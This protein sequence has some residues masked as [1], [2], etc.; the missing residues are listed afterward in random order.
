MYI[1]KW[2]LLCVVIGTSTMPM[3]LYAAE[4]TVDL[5][6][7]VALLKNQLQVLE[8]R[9]AT[10]DQSN[11]DVTNDTGTNN[12][13]NIADQNKVSIK[14]P[15]PIQNKIKKA[16]VTTN[17]K[18][19]AAVSLPSDTLSSTV[20]SQKVNIAS[21]TNLPLSWHGSDISALIVGGATA[22][23]SKSFGG[24]NSFNL[25]DLNPVLLFSYK[26]LILMRSALNFAIND[27]GG[28]DVSLDNVN[29][30]LFINDYMIFGIGKFDSA[31]GSFIQNLS[32]SWVNRLPDSP[33]GFSSDQAAPQSEIGVQ[34]RGGLPLIADINANYILFIANGPQG[35][36]DTTN[37][38]IDH[39]ST[40]GFTNNNGNFITG[41]RIGILPI[42]E[43]EIGI[44]GAIGKLALIDMADNTTLLQ[45][46]RNYNVIGIDAAYKWTNWDLKAEFIEQHVPSQKNSIVTQA[47]SWKAWYLQMAYRI[48]KTNFEP[49]LRYGKYTTSVQSQYQRQLAFGLDYWLTPS[50][51]AQA[52]Y[53]LNYAQENTGNNAN[54][55]LI[56]LV[57]G[58]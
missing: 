38:I 36:V 31:I 47:E 24:S 12:N 3:H 25:L 4:K 53:E 48:P 8:S 7:E 20:S 17:H 56:Q 21:N 37:G 51:A 27:Q 9:I 5:K 18:S 13:A 40:D 54:S 10:V 57:F 44:S 50:I 15:D 28:T 58:Y 2:V 49:V 30:N 41:G 45:K 14:K 52:A 42:P 29:L 39:V 22:G 35:M 6:S 1:L 55:F 46:G 11:A 19:T 23:Y 26:D 33:V 16:K 43:L 32:P 34:L